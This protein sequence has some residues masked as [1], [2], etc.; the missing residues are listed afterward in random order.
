MQHALEAK[1]ARHPAIAET[2]AST[3]PKRLIYECAEDAYW[4]I[5][6]DGKGIIVLLRRINSYTVKLV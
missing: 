5:G 6:H 1:F 4:G 3:H 2:L